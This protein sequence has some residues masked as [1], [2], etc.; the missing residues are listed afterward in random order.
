MRIVQYMSSIV[1][2]IIDEDTI[3]IFFSN[4]VYGVSLAVVKDFYLN[5]RVVEI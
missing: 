1:F 3:S 2:W 4:D 5:I